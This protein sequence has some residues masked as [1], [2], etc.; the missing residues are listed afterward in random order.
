MQ[1]SRVRILLPLRSL[2][3]LPSSCR[4]DFGQSNTRTVYVRWL[5]RGVDRWIR[6]R[7]YD[8]S[9]PAGWL[10]CHFDNRLPVEN[11]RWLGV[12]SCCQFPYRQVPRGSS[13]PRFL[14]SMSKIIYPRLA[15]AAS[16]V[17]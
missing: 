3:V 16:A 13:M 14:S 2:V 9:A 17:C 7:S 8:F 5:N 12:L 15:R 10:S 6:A 1:E 11:S 4:D